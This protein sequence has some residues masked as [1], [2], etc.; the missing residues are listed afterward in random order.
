M[1][2]RKIDLSKLNDYEIS[3]LIIERD[4]CH[5]KAQQ[6]TDLLNKIGESK[7]LTDTAFPTQKNEASQLT[8]P[9]DLTRLPWKS[10]KTK[11]NAGPEEAGW[12]FAKTSGAETLLATLKTKDGQARSGNF[13][14]KLQGQERQFIARTPI[15]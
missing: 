15:K 7:K 10:Y 9:F 5:N 14:Y 8:E 6:I 2:E 13:D 11:E 1:S 3:M 12:I 4:T